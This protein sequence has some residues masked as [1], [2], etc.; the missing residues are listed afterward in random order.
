MKY[1]KKPLV[2]EAIQYLGDNAVAV[3]K[4]LQERGRELL[5]MGDWRKPLGI[6]TPHG[7]ASLEPLDWVIFADIDDIYPC[8]PDVFAKTYEPC[9]ETA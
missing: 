1:R 3:D 5:D 2:V 6:S 8:D 7:F 9:E 4:W